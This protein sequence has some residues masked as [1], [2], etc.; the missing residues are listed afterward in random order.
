MVSHYIAYPTEVE[1]STE[2]T[3][4]REALRKEVVSLGFYI[5]KANDT[6]HIE[7]ESVIV[8]YIL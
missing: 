6:L 4:P 5:Y 7:C 1:K 8:G 3:A 2:K